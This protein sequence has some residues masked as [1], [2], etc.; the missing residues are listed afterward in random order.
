[1]T[2]QPGHRLRPRRLGR[3]L[4][5]RLAPPG[6][7]TLGITW[8][9]AA[10]TARGGPFGP[11]PLTCLGRRVD[12]LPDFSDVQI[13]PNP[14]CRGPARRPG[15]QR[16]LGLGL[17]AT[18]APADGSSPPTAAPIETTT[19]T[20]AAPRP[21]PR[22]PPRRP[23]PSRSTPPPWPSPPARPLQAGQRRHPHQG[24]PA[25]AEGPALRPGRARREVRHQDHHGGVG[26]P[27]APRPPGRR[28]RRPADRGLHPGQAPRRA[29][30]GPS[31]GPTHTEVDLT[32][33]VMIVWRDGA[34]R[35]DHPRVHRQRRRLLRGHQ[36]REEL[37]RRGRPPPAP[38]PS[39]AGSRA[40]ARRRSASSTT[41]CTSTA[42][43]P[44]TAPRR[45]PTTRP[46]TAASASR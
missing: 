21:P 9:D 38:T 2:P 42:A 29:C 30:C 8:R 18:S 32:K 14:R 6:R 16:L 25:G 5:R 13:A 35:A 23:R 26:V 3:G 37:R 34:A 46:A 43:S 17:G 31:L 15:D 22:R 36:G 12:A 39:A 33:Q 24:R 19:S 11:M 28:H 4:P 40:G 20:T 10:G 1:M 44:C 27:A 41:R 7:V 45:C